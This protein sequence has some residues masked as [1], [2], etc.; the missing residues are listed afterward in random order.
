ML[1]FT[2]GLFFDNN[3]VSRRRHFR[4]SSEMN[5]VI[6]E[7]WN[8]V[9]CGSDKV[10]ILGGVGEFGYLPELSGEKRIL[11]SKSEY[12][13]FE[14]YVNGVTD[15]HDEAYDREM[16]ETYVMQS[17]DVRGGVSFFPVQYS[18]LYSGRSVALSTNG[19]LSSFDGYY[20]ILGNIGD[21]QR[22]ISNGINVDLSVNM[23]YPVSEVD[24]EDLI[25]RSSGCLIHE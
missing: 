17:Y 6:I 22:V 18:K 9:V 24:I 25:S 12:S 4:D 11:I 3:T 8:K 16:F 20:N 15:V 23:L 5:R 19:S 21:F 2:S 7:N 14:S 10:Y 13:F 1:F